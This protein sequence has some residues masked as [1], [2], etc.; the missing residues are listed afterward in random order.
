MISLSRSRF[1]RGASVVGNPFT[2]VAPATAVPSGPVD[3]SAEMEE[4]W[5]SLG[6][7]SPGRA[8]VVQFMSAATGEGV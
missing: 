5:R 8:R 6:P 2:A 4:L 1:A 7:V 3:L